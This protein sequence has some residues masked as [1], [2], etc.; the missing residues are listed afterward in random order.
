MPEGHI[1]V[2]VSCLGSRVSGCRL[3]RFISSVTEPF[4][5]A[6]YLSPR[7]D[8]GPG[9]LKQSVQQC[10]GLKG[11]FEGRDQEV[12]PWLE[13]AGMVGTEAFSFLPAGTDTDLSTCNTTG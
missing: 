12:T 9:A 4:T 11:L 5:C 6:S 13:L 3:Q 8:H 7:L 2:Q 1:Y 10:R